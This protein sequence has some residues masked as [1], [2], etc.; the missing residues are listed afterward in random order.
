MNRELEKIKYDF[1]EQAKQMDSVLGAWNFVK[2]DCPEDLEGVE[3][4]LISCMRWFQADAKEV[5]DLKGLDYSTYLGD[6]VINSW[7]SQR[8]DSV[9][10][11][12]LEK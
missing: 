4:N 7:I 6:T 8:T 3:Q 2:Y 12:G 10:P 9:L 1:I 5:N 11:N